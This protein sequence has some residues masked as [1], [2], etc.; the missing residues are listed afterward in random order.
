MKPDRW[1]AL[2]SRMQR[3]GMPSVFG[4]KAGLVQWHEFDTN[5]QAG[6]FIGIPPNEISMCTSACAMYKDIKQKGGWEFTHSPPESKAVAVAEA[7]PCGLSSEE[8]AGPDD[9]KE[10]QGEEGVAP[11]RVPVGPA[12]AEAAKAAQGGQGRAEGRDEG[13]EAHPPPQEGS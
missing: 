9:P 13:G 2:A 8:G 12:A 3:G 6:F 11:V 1:K 4:R 7:A 10:Q 5:K